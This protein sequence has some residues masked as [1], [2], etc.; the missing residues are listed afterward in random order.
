MSTTNQ[1]IKAIAP[2]TAPDEL[3]GDFADNVALNNFINNTR[4]NISKIIHHLDPRLVVIVGPCSIHD[5]DAALEYAH[6]LKDVREKHRAELE[7]VMR[8]Y[9]EKPRSTIGWKGLIN[10]PDLDGSFNVNKG[11]RVSRDLLLELNT[12]GVPAACEFLDAVT[13]QYYADLVSWG[14]IGARTT[15]S[16]IHR[17]LASGLSCP[18]GFK[19]GTNGNID[20]AADAVLAASIEHVFPGLTEQGSSALFTTTGNQDTHIILRGGKNPNYDAE[21][22]A[23]AA[24]ALNK[25]SINTGLMIDMSH[26]NSQKQHQNQLKVGAVI[27]DQ[28]RSGCKHIIGC[29]IES[30]LVEGN[31]K[32]EPGKPLVYGQSI[33]DACINFEQSAELI[34]ELASAVRERNLRE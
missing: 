24:A 7:I 34:S 13:A 4:A 8:V 32:A 10:D 23:A 12:L 5:V 22:V 16:Q 29:M 28:I 11:L 21:N 26:A 33:T 25:R 19:N 1:R 3:I 18:I 17:E 14:A 30:H 2:L 20:I 9:F 27:A 15:E 6:L 31:Q